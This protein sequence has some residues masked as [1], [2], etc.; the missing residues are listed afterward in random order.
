MNNKKY[1]IFKD[2][3]QLKPL[4]CPEDFDP[5]TYVPYFKHLYEDVIVGE[6][7]KEFGLKNI[8]M[9]PM[10]DKIVVSSSL[11]TLKNGGDK[12]LLKKMYN[13][14]YL[15]TGVKPILTKSSVA[16][17]QFKLQKGSITGCK[18]TLRKNY[19]YEFLERLVT[20]YLPSV[21]GF[22]GIPMKS[23][24]Q[25]TLNIGIEDIHVVREA[26]NYLGLSQFGCT[27]TICLKNTKDS[28]LT[29]AVLKK[30]DIPIKETI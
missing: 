9:V 1:L 25:N 21:K 18:S 2:E 15:M 30:F 4:T 13:T 27:I 24:N 11:S 26:T 19:I 6:I 20:I 7:M 12:E 10:I 28:K 17:S 3:R 8:F 5:K 16:I 22:L 14:L 23:I 29:A